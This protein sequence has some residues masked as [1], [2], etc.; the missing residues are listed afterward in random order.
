MAMFV[1]AAGAVVSAVGAI[2]KG[3]AE[4][5]AANYNAAIMRQNADVAM[6]QSDAADQ[7]LSR[8]A[9]GVQGAAI[10]AYGASGVTSDSG[11]AVDVLASSARNASLDQ[12][13][14][15]YNYKL[16]ALGFL[17][18]AGLDSANAQNSM[19]AGYLNATSSILRGASSMYSMGGGGSVIPTTGG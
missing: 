11:S 16:K 4:A 3:Q 13:T 12:L 2:R 19:Q 14:S 9:E 1:L 10:A 18:Q 5:G 8:R 6:S 7:M 17:D 15:R